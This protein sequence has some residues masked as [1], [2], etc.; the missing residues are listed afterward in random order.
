MLSR[1]RAGHGLWYDL[2]EYI[3]ALLN[4][5]YDA[6]MI[7]NESGLERPRQ[8]AWVVSAQARPP[9]RPFSALASM[10]HSPQVHKPV[11]QP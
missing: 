2:A 8:N 1:L 3:P 7:E 9:C 11:R 10:I 6:A 4:D 5:G